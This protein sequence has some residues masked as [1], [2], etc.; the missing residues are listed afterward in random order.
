P[1]RRAART[2]AGG[3]LRIPVGAHRGAG[4]RKRTGVAP[5]SRDPGAHRQLPAQRHS[6]RLLSGPVGRSPRSRDRLISPIRMDLHRYQIVRSMTSAPS[7]ELRV[8]VLTADTNYFKPI[9]I[10]L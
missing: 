7:A 6:I 5:A 4:A 2:G 1:A 8:R 10:S 3:R 9:L